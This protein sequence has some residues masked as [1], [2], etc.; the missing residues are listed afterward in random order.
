[1]G[2]HVYWTDAEDR[3]LA[4]LISE[5]RGPKVNALQRMRMKVRTS[6]NSLFFPS[7]FRSPCPPANFPFPPPSLLFSHPPSDSTR[8]GP[9]SPSPLATSSRSP[10]WSGSRKSSR[11]RPDRVRKDDATPTMDRIR[12][13]MINLS[14]RRRDGTRMPI[15]IRS[16]DEHRNLNLDRRRRPREL[17]S[18]RTRRRRETRTM[19]RRLVL[20]TPSLLPQTPP[21]LST[22]PTRQIQDPTLTL[23][24]TL[25]P[26]HPSKSPPPPPP[27]PLDSPA[28]PPPP[29]PPPAQTSN[30]PPS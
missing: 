29:A 25:V 6:I 14:L 2:G 5:T 4:A 27:L 23:T 28:L 9:S 3:E 13:R 19:G 8:Q 24:P 12:T 18:R 26:L 30:L 21:P 17:D 22:T 1:M 15:F 7:S 10:S 20:V 16:I 11:T